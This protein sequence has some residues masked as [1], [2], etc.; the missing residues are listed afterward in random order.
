MEW[1]FNSFKTCSLSYLKK[2]NTCWIAYSGGLDSHVLLH[3]A[4]QLRDQENITVRAVH[5]HHGL[6][7]YADEWA[8]HCLAICREL[9]IDFITHHLHL[10]LEPGDS[11]EEVARDARY[12]LFAELLGPND[13]LFTAHQKDD[14]AETVLLQLLRGAGIKGL[15]AMPVIKPLGAGWHGRPLLLHTRAQLEDYARLYKLQW[16]DDDSNSNQRFTRNFL[17]QSIMPALKERF[18]SAVE[19]LA[20]TAQHCAEAQACLEEGVKQ[21][22]HQIRK[23]PYRLSVSA[24]QKLSAQRQRYVLRAFLSDIGFPMPSTVKLMEIQ[25]QFLSAANDRMPC[26]AW[27][28]V[29]LRRYQDELYAMPNLTPHDAQR[30]FTWDLINPLAI[31]GVGVI[32]NPGLS[33]IYSP[34]TVRFRRGGESCQLA[35]RSH[36]HS[37]KKLFQSWGVPP[38]WR[39][40]I[41]L[42]YVKDVLVAVPGYY[43]N[44]AYKA[45]TPITG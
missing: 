25:T 33:R 10:N 26:I 18:P 41:P 4:K 44:E 23:D 1:L 45:K 6:S 21:D 28:S 36:T 20:R 34:V 9:K 43:L 35:G 3:L 7:R 40:R 12:R 11:L 14:Q 39:D 15:S 42:I 31:P 27:E 30:E 38:W 5:I 16:I 32:H 17:R 13:V 37:L 8:R 19:T 22:L 24:L 2:D 29:E